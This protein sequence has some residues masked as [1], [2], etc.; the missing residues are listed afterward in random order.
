M[1]N[2]AA[3]PL[4]N[5]KLNAST[6]RVHNAAPNVMMAKGGGG[7]EGKVNFNLPHTSSPPHQQQN[8]GER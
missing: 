2:Q 6:E 7:H 1:K 5:A 4:M 3:K 8:I